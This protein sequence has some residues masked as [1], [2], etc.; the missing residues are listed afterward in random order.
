MNYLVL[1]IKNILHKRSRIDAEEIYKILLSDNA[2]PS[3]LSVVRTLSYFG[4]KANVFRTD[5]EHLKI[6][7]GNKIIH[8]KLGDG[9]FFMIKEINENVVFLYDGDKHIYSID[10]LKEIWDGVVIITKD[11]KHVKIQKH[12]SSKDL[13]KGIAFI[14]FIICAFMLCGNDIKRIQI[15]FD[16]FGFWASYAL[17]E[18]QVLQFSNISLCKI[19]KYIDCDKVLQFNPF[20]VSLHINIPLIC[21][22]FFVIDYISILFDIQETF[23]I[24]MYFMSSVFA[25]FLFTCQIF[26]IKRYCLFCI[27]IGLCVIIKCSLSLALFNQKPI[28]L[29][30]NLFILLLCC[31]I[32]SIAIA[33]F[34]N[35]NLISKNTLINQQKESM[36]LKRIPRLFDN[37]LVRNE[38]IKIQ[39]QPALTFG[40]KNGKIVIDMF[41]KGNCSH[42]EKAIS[43]M[44]HVLS[45]YEDT[46]TWNI[47]FFDDIS[48]NGKNRSNVF[49]LMELFKRDSYAALKNL[50]KRNIRLK[51]IKISFDTEKTFNDIQKY[52]KRNNINYFPFV[53]LNG[54]LY[55]KEFQLSDLDFLI[56][57]WRFLNRFPCNT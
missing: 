15:V 39:C 5:I 6:E 20:P 42:C 44:C 13:F 22:F 24:L 27:G 16:I 26:I 14:S 40:T 57:D 3:A 38:Y 23:L 1:I 33:N 45:K 12:Y 17:L 46:I 54:K 31:F 55:P 47:Y 32:L 21:I 10:K 56:N 50:K 41:V 11:S 30:L 36:T 49:M 7:K 53:L 2:Y 19:G 8:C 48:D 28:T 18:K 35:Q 25:L 9:H 43:S 37:Q 51:G 4:L 29:S 52:I 34:F